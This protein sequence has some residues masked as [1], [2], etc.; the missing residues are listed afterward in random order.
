MKILELFTHRITDKEVSILGPGLNA[1]LRGKI[2]HS[3]Q[4]IIFKTEDG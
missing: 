4:E 2:F 1:A 3:S